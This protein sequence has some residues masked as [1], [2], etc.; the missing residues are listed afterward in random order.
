MG[1]ARAMNVILT[2]GFGK[3]NRHEDLYS[4]RIWNVFCCVVEL[5]IQCHTALGLYLCQAVNMLHIGL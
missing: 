3:L 5:E 4:Y 1:S 2:G